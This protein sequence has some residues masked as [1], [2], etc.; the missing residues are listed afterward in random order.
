M[1]AMM[2][3]GSRCPWWGQMSCSRLQYGTLRTFSRRPAAREAATARHML[4]RSSVFSGHARRA[5]TVAASAPVKSEWVTPSCRRPVTSRVGMATVRWLIRFLSR[6]ANDRSNT[7][8]SCASAGKRHD[9]DDFVRTSAAGL[10]V[11]SLQ[12]R[13]E[14]LCFQVVRPYVCAC[15][16][17]EEFPTGLPSTFSL[18][19][20]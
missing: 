1:S 12:V 5:V 14:A 3:S 8:H 4:D 15:V 18:V 6:H 2:V 11:M 7:V 16:R 17:A 9:G 10:C 20:F 19:F 13:S